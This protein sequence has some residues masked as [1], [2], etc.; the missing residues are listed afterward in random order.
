MWPCT[1]KSRFCCPTT[2]ISESTYAGPVNA[3]IG[4][5][6]IQRALMHALLCAPEYVS[7]YCT[8]MDS[9]VKRR[10]RIVERSEK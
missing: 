9:L 10:Q 1:R 4:E 5:V 3:G 6:C 8:L 7:R 2:A